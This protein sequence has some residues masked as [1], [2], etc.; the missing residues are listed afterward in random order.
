MCLITHKIE[1]FVRYKGHYYSFTG[2]GV[3]TG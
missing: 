1:L 3:P 2:I